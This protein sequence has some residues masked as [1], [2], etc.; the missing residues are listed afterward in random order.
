VRSKPL[1]NLLD[2]LVYVVIRIFVC[3]VQALPIETCAVLA[4]HL[5]TLCS[6]ILGIRGDVIEENLRH[7][8]PEMSEADRR[9]L[10]W[11]MWE[12]LFLL[13]IEVVHAPRK[14]HDT[15]WRQYVTLVRADQ[16]VRAFFDDRPTVVVCGHYGNFELSG[17]VLGILGFPTFTIARPLDNP[18]LDRFL[19]AFRGLSG[20]Y[21][22]SKTGSS[23]QVE[24]ILARGGILAL[25]G[26][27]NA[28]PK[29]CWVEFFG[30][31]ASSHKAIALFTLASEAPT[32]F[33]YTRRTGKPLHQELGL[34][35]MLDPRTMPSEMQSVPGITQWYTRQLEETIRQAP[36]Q[37]WWLHRRWK[38]TR[39]K[40]RA[41]VQNQ[42]A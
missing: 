8:F 17:H 21:I 32:L 7:A 26:D 2:Y 40:R 18:Y 34:G 25:L 33:C 29:G 24:A 12:H 15:N 20:Q 37:Y 4:G 19:N 35:G 28:G 16:I 13:F 39:P 6:S 23:Q 27:Q 41:S 9:A 30:R 31:P 14:I 22:L 1:R 38:D 42:A 36:E 3:V 5:A 11:R 10:S